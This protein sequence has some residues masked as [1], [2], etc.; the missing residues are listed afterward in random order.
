MFIGQ[1]KHEIWKE[2]KMRGYKAVRFKRER[3]TIDEVRSYMDKIDH[4]FES[5]KVATFKIYDVKV[6]RRKK[7]YSIA[8]KT[9]GSRYHDLQE[10]EFVIRQVTELENIPLDY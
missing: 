3:V 5:G 2:E 4:E 8:T 10:R 7:E 9:S 1:N 6:E